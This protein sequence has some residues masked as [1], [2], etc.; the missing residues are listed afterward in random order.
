MEEVLP[1]GAIPHIS[2]ILSCPPA[3]EDVLAGVG[4]RDKVEEQQPQHPGSDG[5]GQPVWS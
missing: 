3:L 1:P 2:S 5:G 4:V